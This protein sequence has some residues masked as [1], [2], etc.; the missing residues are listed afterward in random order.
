MLESGTRPRPARI[1]VVAAG[2]DVDRILTLLIAEGHLVEATANAGA[3]TMRLRTSPVLDLALIGGVTDE[4]RALVVET[5]RTADVWCAYLHTT[6]CETELSQEERA[7]FLA[8]IDCRALDARIVSTITSLVRAR[9]QCDA[10][11]RG[12]AR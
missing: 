12:T 5:A 8:T 10:A 4:Q 11:T 7:D 9:R 2:P 6:S 1:L 3:A